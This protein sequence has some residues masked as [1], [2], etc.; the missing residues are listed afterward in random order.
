VKVVHVT[1]T[2][3]L[4]IV[5]EGLRPLFEVTPDIAVAGEVSAPMS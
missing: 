1:I 3:D 5:R 4:A 2:D